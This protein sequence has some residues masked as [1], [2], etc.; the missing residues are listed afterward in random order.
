MRISLKVAMLLSM[1]MAISIYPQI[2]KEP[3]VVDD[4]YYTFNK[5]TKFSAP[6]K[7]GEYEFNEIRIIFASIVS[8]GQHD[9]MFKDIKDGIYNFVCSSCQPV[10]LP[11][12]EAVEH[13]VCHAVVYRYPTP[14]TPRSLTYGINITFPYQDKENIK[15]IRKEIESFL[16]EL[17]TTKMPTID[18]SLSF[19]KR[20][21]KVESA[22]K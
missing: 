7:K 9:H 17:V 3:T 20:K 22:V 6:V 1:G 15:R 13:S 4:T 11:S 16:K 14:L 5:E 18:Y 10:N 21:V 19:H 2:L 8:E 12:A